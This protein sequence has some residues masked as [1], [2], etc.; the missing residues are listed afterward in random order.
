MDR[1]I[2]VGLIQNIA[3]LLTFSM[4]YDLFWERTDKSRNIILRIASGFVLGGIGI[5]LILSPWTF[6]TGL[7][8]DTRSVMLCVT[9][10][11]FGPIP[12]L[13][14]M[15]IVGLYRLSLGGPGVWM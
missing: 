4:L 7:F 9:G 11:F 6:K 10:L 14:A 12:T 3:I 2:V 8:F 5:I 15:T 13:I 1:A